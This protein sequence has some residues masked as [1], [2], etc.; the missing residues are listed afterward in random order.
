MRIFMQN[1]LSKCDDC[2]KLNEFI[3][4]QLLKSDSG[5]D[6]AIDV[7]D[8]IKKCECEDNVNDEYEDRPNLLD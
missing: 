4:N 8:F 7:Y 1:K 6:L 2:E 5:F 3:K